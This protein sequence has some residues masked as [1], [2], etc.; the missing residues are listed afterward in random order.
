MLITLAQN[1]HDYQK[2]FLTT[3]PAFLTMSKKKKLTPWEIAKL[4]LEKDYVLANCITDAM[5]PSDVV[6]HQVE[7]QN[8]VYKIFVT[9]FRN[10]KIVIK[11]LRASAVASNVALENDCRFHPIAANPANFPYPRWD[12]HEAQCLLKLDVDDNKHKTMKPAHLQKTRH[13]YECCPLPVF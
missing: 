4:L 8:V 3:I 9:N 6:L 10:L 11:K 13:Q 7:Y 12:G 5:K 2:N 1:W